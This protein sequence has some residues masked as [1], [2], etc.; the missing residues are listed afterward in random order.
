MEKPGRHIA[1]H[2][3]D[4]Q[5]K[6]LIIA[7]SA[8]VLLIVDIMFIVSP[9]MNKN[10]DLKRQ[11][12]VVKAKLIELQKKINL[13]DAAKKRS[14]EL[15]AELATYEKR[16]PREEEIP[17]FLEDLSKVAVAS[18]ID[19][20]AIKPVT[21]AGLQAPPDAFMNLF[22]KIPIEISAKAGYHQI[23]RFINSLE[24]LERFIEIKDI[25]ISQDTTTPRRHQLKL[26]IS[27]CILR[28]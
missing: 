26:V 22:H 9:L 10:A 20:S 12:V 7:A 27:T 18:G 5:R 25:Q 8:I 16:F 24:K 11:V 28:S 4:E 15:R 19:I 21:K 2:L 3:S 1:F 6:L 23:G 13:A 17:L 14:E